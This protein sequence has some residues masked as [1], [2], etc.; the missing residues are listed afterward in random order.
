MISLLTSPL[1]WHFQTPS[2]VDLSSFI[3][4]CVDGSLRN[5][6]EWDLPGEYRVKREGSL[7][8]SGNSH[9]L[10][11]GRLPCPASAPASLLCLSIVAGPQRLVLFFFFPPLESL[12]VFLFPLFILCEIV[13][14]SV[15]SIL[16]LSWVSEIYLIC[17]LGFLR[18]F[19]FIFANAAYLKY[20]SSFPSGFTLVI[21]KGEWY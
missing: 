12:I 3:C 17:I 18:E 21:S 10:N 9:L 5:R 6:W 20:Y 16:T 4:M 11:S 8:S 13:S 1:C 19:L 7:L 2:S 15:I 14:K